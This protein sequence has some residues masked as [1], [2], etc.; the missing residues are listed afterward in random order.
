VT[1]PATCLQSPR[2]VQF[3]AF[4]LHIASANLFYGDNP[5]NTQ[6][7]PKAWSPRLHKG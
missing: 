1:V 7:E 6:A 2:W 4:D 5:M 3:T